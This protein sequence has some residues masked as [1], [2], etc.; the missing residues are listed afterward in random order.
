[1][2]TTKEYGILVT[3]DID[4]IQAKLGNLVESLS[5]IPDK[6]IQ[7]TTNVNDKPVKEL[8]AELNSLDGRIVK[9]EVNADI[10]DAE[11]DVKKVN[12]DVKSIPDKKTIKIDAD[13]SQ[14][15]NEINN[16]Q[17]MLDDLKQ[18]V[19]DFAA[20]A[21]VIG[22]IEGVSQQDSEMSDMSK[23][24]KELSGEM[25]KVADQ[26]YKVTNADWSTIR[27][28]VQ[29]VVGQMGLTGDAAVS[30]TKQML[31]FQKAYPWA[32]IYSQSRAISSMMK[33]MGVDAQTAFNLIALSFAK[34]QDPGQDLLDTF[35][36]Y[37]N[38]FSRMGFSAQ[39]F[40]NYLIEGLQEGAFNSD[41]LAD[42]FKELTIRISEN[43]DG[44]IAIAKQMGFTEAQANALA[45][46]IAKGGPA[47]KDAVNQINSKFQ[48][49]PQNL[50][51]QLGPSLYGTMYEDL[52]EK[53]PNSISKALSE[54][55]QDTNAAADEAGK[56]VSDQV[57]QSFWDG[58][59]QGLRSWGLGPLVDGFTSVF[60]DA[61][62]IIMAFI[63]GKFGGSLPKIVQ[64]F[65]DMGVKVSDIIRTW[66]WGSDAGNASRGLFQSIEGNIKDTSIL[67]RIKTFGDD[68]LTRIRGWGIWAD[69]AGTTTIDMV[70]SVEKGFE[71]KPSLIQRISS[72]GSTVMET[73]SKSLSLPKLPNMGGAIADIFKGIPITAIADIGS[74]IAIPITIILAGLES[75]WHGADLYNQNI[76]TAFLD[77]LGIDD[78]LKAVGQ[79][80]AW[81]NFKNWMTDNTGSIRDFVN[82]INGT[83]IGDMLNQ[84]FTDIQNTFQSS[85]DFSSV[86]G[87]FSSFYDLI[88]S[89]FRDI[90][91]EGPAQWLQRVFDRSIELLTPWK[92]AI[93]ERISGIGSTITQP[94][95]DAWNGLMNIDW[96]SL[97]YNIG[98]GIGQIAIY[99]LQGLYVILSTLFALPGQAYTA[100]L[101]LGT[102][103]YNGLIAV[104][105]QIYTGLTGI[106]NQFISFLNW[107]AGLPGAAYNYILSLGQQT[108]AGINTIPGQVNEGLT[109]VEN[110]FIRF[111]N[112]IGGLPGAAYNYM[113]S[114]GQQTYVGLAAI[115]GQVYNGLVAIWNQF[116]AFIGWIAG[117]PGQFYN[118]IVAAWDGFIKGIT[119][120]LPQI[121]YWL[122]QIRGLFPHSPPKW[123]PLV[124][125]MDW[126]GNMADAIQQGIDAKFP[127]VASS[128]A[129]QLTILKNMGSNVDLSA[130]LNL[131][132]VLG[133][134]A[135]PQATLQNISTPQSTQQ[136]TLKFGDI[137]VE[138]LS[139]E[140]GTSNEEVKQKGQMMGKEMANTLSDELNT[141]IA[142]RGI[143]K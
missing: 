141:Q 60:G 91:E 140:M 1:M 84:F 139:S 109:G 127:N 132:G 99:F 98:A 97:G 94:F 75:L 89:P 11:N 134:L 72:F 133:S 86:Q 80:G 57:N 50:K 65:R 63:I 101:N 76:V 130:S 19:I 118:A 68:V 82:F 74:K 121:T 78:I 119:D 136:V 15:E 69:E 88:A 4:D 62:P 32:D 49:L 90:Q 112:W 12:S 124:D 79:G 106:Y 77:L 96:N 104:P 40:T 17:D 138:V 105:G 93:W 102:W 123:G 115:P 131:N 35:W 13:G 107:L 53:I 46:S 44:F 23:S 31:N 28:A 37:S 92:D 33:N 87:F 61:I 120:R 71:M 55:A 64:F 38:Q 52:R 14:A 27:E 59:V 100:I 67:G 114:L 43:R 116:T 129:N 9:T 128:L 26:V 47:A 73:L 108:Q 41:K 5:K 48:T 42:G 111:M 103:I 2:A 54:S 24:S 8:D 85:I 126:G 45:D 83:K 34:T 3:G 70:G 56:N 39:E 16:I 81:D 58:I 30:M 6:I 18:T 125:I 20:G 66:A 21:A 36:E 143:L 25:K 113:I 95:Q 51:D 117:L 137:K 7:L 10:S 135:L 122:D 142:N 22:G 29:Y 110:Q